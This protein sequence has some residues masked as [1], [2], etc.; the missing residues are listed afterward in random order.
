MRLS[1]YNI[2]CLGKWKYFIFA[3]NILKSHDRMVKLI[4]EALGPILKE[5]RNKYP[6]QLGKMVKFLSLG[7]AEAATT[8]KI[9]PYW[10]KSFLLA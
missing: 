3:G 6:L 5:L 10:R 7:R 9:L 1:L 4:I 8:Q 2:Y